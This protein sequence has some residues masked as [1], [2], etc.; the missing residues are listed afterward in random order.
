[1]TKASLTPPPRAT[2]ADVA[3][4]SLFQG[5]MDGTIPPGSPL[6]LQD[7]SDQLGMSMMPIREAIKRLE[8]LGVVEVIPHKGAWVRPVSLDDLY[9]TLFTRVHLESIALREAAKRGIAAES[10]EQARQ[11]AAERQEKLEA[12]DLLGSRDAHERFHF[13]LYEASGSN[14]LVH[15]IWPV[16]RNSERYR[17]SVMRDPKRLIAPEAE[18]HLGMLEAVESDDGE[19]AVRLIVEH[20]TGSYERVSASLDG[21]ADG[22]KP[23]KLPTADDLLCGSARPARRSRSRGSKA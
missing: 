14:W 5:I 20:L 8:A 17:G 23:K 10:A 9:D 3:Q 12:G 6:R 21:E 19:G 15:S 16:W 1:M 2:A 13:A 4:A 18:Q 11:A 7:L 22:G